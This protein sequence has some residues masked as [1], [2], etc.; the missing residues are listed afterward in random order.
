MNVSKG[1]SLKLT[2]KERG[3]QLVAKLVCGSFSN[4]VARLIEER[5]AA[6]F[7]TNKQLTPPPA[8]ASRVK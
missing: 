2:T 8:A 5:Y 7:P 4:L 3:D 1:I 6:E